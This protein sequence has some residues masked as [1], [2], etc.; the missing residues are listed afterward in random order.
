MLTLRDSQ[1]GED[2]LLKEKIWKKTEK[3]NQILIFFLTFISAAIAVYDAKE[4]LFP[5]TVSITL[6]VFAAIGFLLSCTLWIKAILFFIN[7]IFLPFTKKNRYVNWLI[8]DGRLRAVMLT[9]PGMGL[10][11]I[12]AVFNGAVGM[13]RHSAWYGSLSA[14]Y[15]F[16]CFMR[17]LA[18]FY[19]KDVYIS[20]N[21]RD[22][23][24]EREWRI[25]RN[26]G[27]ILSLTSIA[28]GGAVIV[29]VCGEGGKSYSGLLIY[30]V[31]TYTFIKMGVAIKNM[32]QVRK[33]KS[34]LMMTLRNISY[35]DALV[36]MLSL[37]TALFAA[38]G[39]GQEEFI[40]WMN[41]LTG[42]VV[43]LMILSLGIYTLHD[44]KKK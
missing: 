38:F 22:N 42:A 24:K 14:Y 37:Q 12:Y 39:K 28:L 7:M 27:A 19:A 21:G 17:F 4:G 36:S 2:M 11:L 31:A 32:I 6:Y 10:N 13:T 15:I 8:R 16:L 29:L 5:Q 33:E 34:Y 43:C 1:E 30:A 35:S 40:H 20:K 18:V 25:Y 26:C 41:A 44:A 23:L 9:L 3:R